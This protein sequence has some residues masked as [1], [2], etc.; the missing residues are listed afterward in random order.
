MV[1]SGS[2]AGGKRVSVVTSTWIATA[3]RVSLLRRGEK[4]GERLRGET[5]PEE[6]TSLIIGAELVEEDRET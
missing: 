3:R 2:L 4:V 5:A 1:L 6:I